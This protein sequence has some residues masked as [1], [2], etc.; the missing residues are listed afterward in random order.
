[1]IHVLGTLSGHGR[2]GK[3]WYSNLTHVSGDGFPTM[4]DVGHKNVRLSPSHF[5]AHL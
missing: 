1:M 5:L 2:L 4:V 3:V